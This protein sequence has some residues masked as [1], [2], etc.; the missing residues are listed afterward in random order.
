[1]LALNRSFFTG[2]DFNKRSDGLGFNHFYTLSAC[3]PLIEDDTEIF[4]MI[5]KRDIPT[6]QCKMSLRGPKSTRND[7][8][9]I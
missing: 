6:I 7:F 5:D 9:L 3:D 1:M 2:V 4:Y 8:I